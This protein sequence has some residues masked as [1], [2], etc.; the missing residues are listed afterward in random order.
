MDVSIIIVSYNT[1]KL[2]KDCLDSIYK[3]TKDITFE[4]IVV[5]NNSSDNSCQVI[6]A[7]CPQVRLIRSKENLGFGKANNL[8]SEHADGKY[9]FYLNSDTILCNNAIKYFFDFAEKSKAQI[10]ALGAILKGTDSKNCHSY[11][12]FITMRSELQ[13][14]LAKY[15][16]ILKDKSKFH[17]QTVTSALEVD[18]I[19]G[20]DLFV[21]T[22]VY[23]EIG[24]FDPDFFMYCEEVDWQQRMADNGYVRYIIPGPEIIHLEGGSEQQKGKKWS[25]RR[26]NNIITSKRIYFK[27]HF[28]GW[29]YPVFRLLYF[30]L[31]TPILIM[32]NFTKNG[33]GTAR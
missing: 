9:L 16:R 15:F 14:L 24:G 5:D 13:E 2:L 11:G 31:Y 27:K 23:K 33:G 6:E 10:G 8:G 32:L 1:C 21:P 17:P 12:N 19:T 29:G 4:V 3:E 20:A 30:I 7:E 22:S 26:L 25:A 18:Y 28:K